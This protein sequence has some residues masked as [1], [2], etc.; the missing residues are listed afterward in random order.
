MYN[1]KNK[2]PHKKP[3]PSVAFVCYLLTAPTCVQ[4][5]FGFS[6]L[7]IADTE[8]SIWAVWDSGAALWS[9]C[10]WYNPLS[11]ILIVALDASLYISPK[12]YLPS[13]P[14]DI[15]TA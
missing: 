9:T 6:S 1:M 13:V 12:N 11:S 15:R 7:N 4:K 5:V 3:T 10:T 8:R 14:H 2:K